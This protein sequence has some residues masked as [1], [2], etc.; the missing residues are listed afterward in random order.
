[1]KIFSFILAF[2]FVAFILKPFTG[3]E[4][5]AKQATCCAKSA[6]KKHADKSEKKDCSNTG[7]N[8]ISCVL[9]CYFMP[10]SGEV[11]F[12]VAPEIREEYISFNDHRLYFISSDCWHPPKMTSL[13]QA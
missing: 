12:V 10:V 9:C 2:A 13:Y 4:P 7:C 6:C 3:I 5:V 8:M 1:V 11:H